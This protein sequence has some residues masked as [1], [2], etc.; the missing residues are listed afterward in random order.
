LEVD[1]I[2]IESEDKDKQDGE[3]FLTEGPNEQPAP[4]LSEEIR[5]KSGSKVDKSPEST[6]IPQTSSG[7]RY[8]LRP[9]RTRNYSNRFNHVMDKLASG[10]SYDVQLLQHEPEKTTSLQE[11]YKRGYRT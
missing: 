3:E 9:N 2:Q 11:A 4:H 7:S 8:G 10:Q 5:S 1:D 6:D